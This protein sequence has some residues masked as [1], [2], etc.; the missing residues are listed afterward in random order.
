MSTLLV[1]TA[2]KAKLIFWS[3]SL[4]GG[5]GGILVSLFG[6]PPVELERCT[7]VQVR[8]GMLVTWLSADHV[9]HMASGWPRKL[10]VALWSMRCP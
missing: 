8:Q 3:I 9:C 10:D 1:S 5:G 6:I 2:A 4:G 7:H